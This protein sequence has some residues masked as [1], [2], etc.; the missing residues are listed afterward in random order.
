MLDQPWL[1]LTADFE[2]KDSYSVTIV[3]TTSRRGPLAVLAVQ[4]VAELDL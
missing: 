2:I 4:R 3:A 1:P